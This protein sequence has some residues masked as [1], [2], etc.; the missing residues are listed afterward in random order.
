MHELGG[1]RV[2]TPVRTAVELARA[3][4]RF[5]ENDAEAVRELGRIGGFGL[6]ECLALMNARRNLPAKRRAAE[7]LAAVFAC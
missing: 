6:E 1:R 7:R 5:G 4:E 2:T 3:R